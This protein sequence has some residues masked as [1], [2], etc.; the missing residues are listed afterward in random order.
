MKLLNLTITIC[1]I[2]FSIFI[3]CLIG[4]MGI[5]I[6]YKGNIVLYP[7]YH[8]DVYYGDFHIRRIQ[9]NSEFWHTNIDGSWKFSINSQGFR[10][11][12]DFNYNKSPGVLRIIALGDSHTQGYEVRQERTFSAVAERYLNHHGFNVE[13]LNAGVSGFGTAEEL[14]FLE[15][16]GYKYSPDFVVLAFYANDME[17]NIKAGLFSLNNGKLT[18]G[19]TEHIP[20]VRIQNIIYSLPFFRFL[21]ENSYLYSYVFN[22]IWD[23]YKRRLYIQEQVKITSEYAIPTRNVT[24]YQ[25]NLAEKLIERVYKFC[26]SK[27]IRLIIV[28]IPQLDN[29]N[30]KTS[31]PPNLKK[32]MID[33][34]DCFIDS[35]ILLFEYRWIGEIHVPHGQRHISELTHLLT[36]IA[37]A[38]NVIKIS[39]LKSVAQ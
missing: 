21:G 39:K 6:F 23:I 33:N 27:D 26:K 1:V 19:K 35:D 16:E 24:E 25:I 2:L 38:K 18:I 37:I 7:R 14:I 29:V 11:D 17:D 12:H 30:F 22:T 10:N 15:N 31:V 28:D 36:G 32:T 8:T 9:P 13:V 34:S 3:A 20:G 4:E 5:R